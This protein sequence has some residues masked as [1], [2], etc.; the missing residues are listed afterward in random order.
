MEERHKK[1]AYILSFFKNRPNQLTKFLI[2]NDA[3][4]DSF[5]E[6]IDK[7]PE[8]KK[9][10]ENIENPYFRD[11]QEMKKFYDGVLSNEL[12][13]LYQERDTVREI[14]EKLDE[15]IRLEKYEDAIRI[16]HYMKKN[17]I[18]RK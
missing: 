3:F 7:I 5:Y 16:R 2:E 8:N 1:I 13:N 18:K 6:K 9:N 17:G 4:K 15:Y 12:N 14:N 10:E 11:F